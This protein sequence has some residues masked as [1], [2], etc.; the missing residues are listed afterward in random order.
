[1]AEP[2]IV[3]LG[4]GAGGVVAVN[5]LHG[6]LKESARI[7]L[8]DR[9]TRQSFPPS[10]LWVMTGERRPDAITRDL[11][12]LERKGIKVVAGEVRRIDLKQRVV[13][14]NK[15]EL[16]YDYLVVALGADL[17]FDAVPGLANA[18][19]FYHLPGAER[20][21]D[22]LATFE[23]GRIVLVIAGLPYKC[24]AA[25]YEAAMLLEGYFHSRHLRHKVE[26]SIYSPEPAPLPVAGPNAGEAIQEMMAHKGITFHSD[27]QITA[28]KK[29]GMRFADGSSSPFDLLVAVPP[30][31]APQ[32]V[33]KA[34]LTDDSGWI[35]VDQHTLE[36]KHEGVFAIGDV[37]RIPL[38]DG[39]LLPK[40]G[41]FAHGQAGVVAANVAAEIQGLA[42]RKQYDGTGY[43]FLEA[44]GGVAGMAQGNFFADP[45]H[46]TIR[47][48]SPVWHWG[49]VAFERYWLWKWY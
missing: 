34:G 23:G 45:R 1:M 29:D 42:K 20:L 25:P 11:T 32:V 7:V 44:G 3:V 43:C 13:V 6:H 35:P 24:P 41:I 14:V 2:T 5:E 28:V 40:A 17:A 8:V 18:H 21:R 4:G 19:T 49:K 9:S 22:A 48:P 16:N 39:M 37:T 12:E 38:P 46:I 30:H 27:K 47:T 31:R 36:T 26:L 10:Y 33:E 15:K